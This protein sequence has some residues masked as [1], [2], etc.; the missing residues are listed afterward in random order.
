MSSQEIGKSRHGIPDVVMQQIDKY[1]DSLAPQIQP[2]IATELETFQQRT[3]DSF[4][5]QIV[6]AF[7]SLFTKEGSGSRSAEPGP[8]GAGS[9]SI[10]ARPP[11]AYGGRALPFAEELASFARSFQDIADGAD[12]DLRQIFDLTGSASPPPPQQHEGQSRGLHGGSSTQGARGFLSAAIEAV[13]EVAGVAQGGGDS[14][15]PARF[16]GILD[17]LSDAVKDA[18]RNPEE[19]A[20]LLGPE[21]RERVGGMLRKHHALIAEKFTRIALDNIKRWLRGNTSTRDLGDG[22]KGEISSLVSGFSS[23]FGHKQAHSERGTDG[24]AEGGRGHGGGLSA[25][26]SNKLS[27]GLAKVH[28][29]VRLEFREVLGGIEKQMFEA[30]PDEVQGPLEKLLGGNPFD[31]ALD[32]SDPGPA[33]RGLGDDLK[34]KLVDSL[35]RLVCKVQESLRESILSTVNGGHR[36]FEGASWRFVQAQVEAK[37]Q[38]V[39]PNIRI[40]VPDDIG[41]EGVSVGQPQNQPSPQAAT[42]AA[43]PPMQPDAASVSQGTAAPPPGAGYYG[44]PTAPAPPA[45]DGRPPQDQPFGEPHASLGGS[46]PFS[47]Q[48]TFPGQQNHDHHQAPP[49]HS[50]PMYSDT[51][52]NPTGFPMAQMQQQQQPYHNNHSGIVAT[53]KFRSAKAPSGRR[54]HQQEAV[55]DDWDADSGNEAAS[56]PN[57][58]F[59]ASRSEWAQA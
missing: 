7:R 49:P 53:Q 38:K 52:P 55:A 24:D 13:S 5:D 45:S 50:N 8:P 54:Q 9:R 41:D 56:R 15:R 21:V 32:A 58:P 34:A 12:N 25:V 27:T 39:L 57:D 31:P 44:S 23:M 42:S 16:G 4:D 33:S 10:E 18:S 1:V 19:K 28:R 11:D 51:Q 35:R 29:N 46:Q 36:K 20:R 43:A 26:I 3:I 6:A 48:P 37:V 30:L 14:G 59:Q 17:I 40:T 47:A 2:L 22:I